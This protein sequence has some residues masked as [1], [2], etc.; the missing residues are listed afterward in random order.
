MSLLIGF[1]TAG[2]TPSVMSALDDII[3]PLQT[4]VGVQEGLNA[5]LAS[6][7]ADLTGKT[8]FVPTGTVLLWTTATAPNG[9]LICN[10]AAVSRVTYSTLFAVI[11]I[12]YGSGDGANTFNLPDLRQR[13]AIGVAAS[14]TGSTLAG[15]GG[16]IDHT[17]T[18]PSHTHTGPSHTHAAGTLAGP[19][20]THAAGTLAGPS[21]TH[22]GPS[23]THPLTG[24]TGNNQELTG[25]FNVLDQDISVV[26]KSIINVH[27]H[28]VGTLA[29][30]AAGTGST[31]AAGTGAVTGCT[32]GDGTGAVTGRTAADGTG[33]VTGSTA[34][35][36]T[37]ATGASGTGATGTA[38]PPFLALNFIVK[39]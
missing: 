23:H 3:A 1:D 25:T 34:A 4:W 28:P 16:T 15:S 29:T 2:I 9:Y 18:G 32:A 6:T 31:G 7:I 26:A 33:A 39:T 36:G 27:S 8:S 10:G 13:F 5:Q 37:G 22:T 11:G 12:L 19:S 14:G 35:D 38:N 24:S 21:H 17:H 20:H 30:S